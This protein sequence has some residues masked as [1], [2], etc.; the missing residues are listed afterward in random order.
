MHRFHFFIAVLPSET[1]FLP[2]D[3]AA[4]HRR[5]C[6]TR[7]S[8]RRPA[9]VPM[10]DFLELR[11]RCTTGNSRLS[12]RAK[13]TGCAPTTRRESPGANTSRANSTAFAP[14][15]NQ[16]GL[17]LEELNWRMRR[18]TTNSVPVE[19]IE[20]TDQGRRASARYH[21]VDGTRPHARYQKASRSPSRAASTTRTP[22]M[23]DFPKP[24]SIRYSKA[25]PCDLSYLDSFK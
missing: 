18:N 6:Q 23:T 14:V 2:G 5:R 22:S 3:H 11:Q 10:D 21:T 4:Q 1:V 15:G 20:W 9:N 19:P 13:P 17:N 24:T 12:R 7:A 25:N 16:V 8:T